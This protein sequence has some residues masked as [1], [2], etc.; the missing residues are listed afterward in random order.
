M[1]IAAISAEVGVTAAA[2]RRQAEETSAARSG[3]QAL[4]VRTPFLPAFLQ[5]HPVV[6]PAQVSTGCDL[7]QREANQ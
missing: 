5:R 3:H 6:W 2:P 7:V 4:N 1:T